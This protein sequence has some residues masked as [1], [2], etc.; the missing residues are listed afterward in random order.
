MKLRVNDKEVETG[1]TTLS[2]LSQE[3]D[4]PA[5]GI[6]VAVNQRMIPRNNWNT[7]PLNEGDSIIIIKA[8]CGG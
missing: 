2:Q 1:A 5:T 7:H 6:A 3:L 4:L 8:V